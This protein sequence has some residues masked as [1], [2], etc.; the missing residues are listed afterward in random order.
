MKKANN[1][2]RTIEEKIAFLEELQTVII[3]IN[4]RIDDRQRDADNNK[5]EEVY[6]DATGLT[7][8]KERNFAP[9]GDY[10]F[11]RDRYNECMRS[12]KALQDIRAYLEKLI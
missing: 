5:F 6:D 12:V 8:K 4:Y 2:T 7:L 9:D 1:V 3:G 11:Y 10:D